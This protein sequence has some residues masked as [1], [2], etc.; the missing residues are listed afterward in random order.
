MGFGA[1][2]SWLFRG[3]TSTKQMQ[4]P[5]QLDPDLHL[6]TDMA[7]SAEHCH[8]NEIFTDSTVMEVK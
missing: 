2:P 7:Q 4:D 3:R 1:F 8:V 5:V 6:S